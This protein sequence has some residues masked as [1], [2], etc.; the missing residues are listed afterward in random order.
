MDKK[1][2]RIADAMKLISSSLTSHLDY[3]YGKIPVD[4]LRR[5]ENARFHKKCV[6][7]YASVLE[8]LAE[9]L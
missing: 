4:A 2:E 9:L 5:G 7:E 8:T 3:T 6:R 1:T